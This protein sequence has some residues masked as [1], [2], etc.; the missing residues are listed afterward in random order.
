[1]SK[2]LLDTHVFIWHINGDEELAKSTR[3]LI[4][5]AAQNNTLYMAAISLWEISMLSLKKRIILGMPCLE[6]INKSLIATRTQ[7]LPLT[8]AIAVESC[9]L[10]GTFHEDPA[11]RLIVSTT[12]IEGLTV[13]TRD[14]K[15]LTYSRSK[16]VSALK[17]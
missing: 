5:I 1:M 16:Y 6:W 17:A 8:P 7:V 10:P 14:S 9:H 15:I 3:K 4:D 12:R 2:F 13:L 11:D